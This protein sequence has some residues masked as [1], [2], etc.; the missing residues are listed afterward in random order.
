MIFT[1][2]ISQNSLFLRILVILFCLSVLLLLLIIYLPNHWDFFYFRYQK[3]S[4][5]IRFNLYY[6][7]SF[8]AVYLKMNSNSNNDS[9]NSSL[10]KQSSP[11]HSRKTINY[12][13]T[14]LILN[15]RFTKT[16]DLHFPNSS[17]QSTST[18]ISSFFHPAT[19][20]SFHNIRKR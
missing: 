20:P 2:G 5:Y 13:F 1:E 9:E 4:S 7:P 15:S 12:D 11:N 18:S 19:T 3:T 16:S 8:A 10:H 6:H 14:I 17:F